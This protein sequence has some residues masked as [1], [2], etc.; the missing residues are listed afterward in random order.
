[1]SANIIQLDHFISSTRDSG[2]K[3]LSSAL[4]ELIDNSIESGATKVHIKVQKQFNPEEEQFEVCVVDNG[5]GMTKEELTVALQFGGSTRFNSRSQ[6]GR[7]GMGLP[8]SSLSQCRRV[9]VISWKNIKSPYFSYLDVDEVVDKKITQLRPPRLVKVSP[10]LLQARSGTI[11]TLKKCDR[12][13]FKYLASLFKQMHNE[14]GRIFRYAIWDGVEITIGD[15]RVAPID[16]LFIKEGLNLKGGKPFGKELIYKVKVSERSKKLS[17][18]RVRFVELPIKDWAHLPNDEKRKARITKN[19]GVSVL[20]SGREIDYGW[21]FMGEKRKEN[22]DDWWR[23]EI[24]FT[25]ELDEAFGVTHTKQEIKETEFMTSILV[26]DLEQTARTLNSRVRLKF[27]DVKKANPPVYAKSQLERTDVYLPSLT[28]VRK[29]VSILPSA[30]KKGGMEYKIRIGSVENH[31]F[32]Q[33]SENKSAIILTINEDHLFYDK[34]FRSLHERKLFSTTD[35]L[36]VIEI[37][38]FSAARSELTLK[39]RINEE[40]INEFKEM[41]SSNLKTLIS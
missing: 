23:C 7:Y 11:V 10:D 25:P 34:I 29:S 9:E 38:I 6:F 26:P 24:S 4:A 37:L 19:A 36:K 8:N 15:K 33:V 18:I 5:K 3:S 1:M 16:P 14:L 21:F 31:H 2:Y 28:K 39:G 32:F 35:F 41:W 12:I 17:E 22:Y 27:M 20:R 40:V 13:A 30:V